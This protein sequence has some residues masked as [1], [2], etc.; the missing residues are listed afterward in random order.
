MFAK[1]WLEQ[2]PSAGSSRCGEENIITITGGIRAL[3]HAGVV[4]NWVLWLQ[5]GLVFD[6]SGPSESF[7]IPEALKVANSVAKAARS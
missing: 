5:E 2:M 1:E 3:Q 4:S 7:S 6:V